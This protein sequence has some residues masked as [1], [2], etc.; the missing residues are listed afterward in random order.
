MKRK[1]LF[2]E[3]LSMVQMFLTNEL[4]VAFNRIDVYSNNYKGLYLTTELNFK[5][6][7][8]NPPQDI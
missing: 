5:N 4:K 8:P 7:E 6:P 2:A 1:V 3:E